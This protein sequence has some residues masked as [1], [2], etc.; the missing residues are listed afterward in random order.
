M[1]EGFKPGALRGEL[2][3]FTRPKWFGV[4]KVDSRPVSPDQP[5]VHPEPAETHQEVGPNAFQEKFLPL[6]NKRG[7]GGR[8][9]KAQALAEG[10]ATPV[11]QAVAEIEAETP[12]LHQVPPR[13]KSWER[14][15][16]HREQD[17]TRQEAE[18]LL[19]VRKARRL[20]IQEEL[21]IRSR[22]RS[23]AKGFAV[24]G[25]GLLLTMGK[26]ANEL[27]ARVEKNAEDLSVRELQQIIQT[28]GTA[29]G[30]AQSAIES[31]ARVERFMDRHELSDAEENKDDLEGLDPEGA[32]L[33]LE[34][35][36]RTLDSQVKTYSKRVID[37]EVIPEEPPSVV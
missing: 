26:A 18:D 27:R 6:P 1:S 30:K 9:T 29:V 21:T 10:K 32:K 25:Q 3:K 14:D 15:Y 8:P 24:V 5:P 28:T 31:M 34:N 20:A 12:P 33:I 17:E 16:N 7:K 22:N 36:K 11:R 19:E 35:L 23:L 4:E 2:P 37:G 13:G